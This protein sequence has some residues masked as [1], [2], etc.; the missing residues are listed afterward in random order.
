LANFALAIVSIHGGAYSD[1]D[2]LRVE[3]GALWFIAAGAFVGLGRLW[4]ELADLKE[5][6][7][8]KEG[9]PKS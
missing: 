7:S 2:N 8:A 1:A 3:I 6:G 5:Q 4:G 9:S